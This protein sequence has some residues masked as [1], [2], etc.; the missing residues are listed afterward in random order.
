M[1]LISR[2]SL[3]LF[4]F[5]SFA[6]AELPPL[7]PREVLFGNPERVQP[8]I[9]PDGKRL[10]W[11]APDKNNVLQVWM[12]TVGGS[13]DKVM[14]ADKKRGIRQY[15]WAPSSRMLLYLQDADGDENFHVYGVDIA[16]GAVRDYTP[17]QGV[18]AGVLDVS[19][20]KPDTLLATVNLRDKKAFD[21]YR[22][23]LANGTTA[24]DT[25]NPGDVGNWVADANLAV[26]GA[27]VVTPDGGT[28]L[29][30]R[31]NA[32]APWKTLL[33]A[34]PEENVGIDGFNGDGG[35]IYLE[36]SIGADT[37]R[38]IEKNLKTGAEREIA[39][40]DE[41]DVGGGFVHPVKRSIIAVSFVRGRGEWRVID[42][43]FRDD[44]D[45]LRKLSEGDF[46]VVNSDDAVDNLLV[47]FTQDRGPVKYFA[48][49]RKDKKGTF[50]FTVQPK[51]E[52]LAL[53]EMKPVTIAA[54]D[55]LRLHGYLT[56]PVGVA[57]K[58]LPL[59]LVV[60]GGPWARD[61]WGYNSWVQW[62]ANRGYAVLQ[63]NFRGSTGFGKKFLHAGDRQ[64][65]KT[66]HDD[67]LDGVAWA[68]KEGYADARRVAVFG[69]SYGGYSAL[70]GAAFT[71]DT[72]RCAVDIVGP[73]NLF[74]LL[75]TIPP[76]WATMRALFDTRVGN[77]EDPKDVELLKQ[78]SPLFS[79]D[80]IKIPMLIGQGANDPRVKPAESEQIVAAI[81]KNGG[82]VTYV[83]YSD[84]GHGFQRPENRMDFNARAEEFL[85]AELGG[86]AE[87]LAGE[88]VAG[89]T[90]QVKVVGKK[91]AA[92][93]KR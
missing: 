3:L 64:W 83:L 63:I 75:K 19:P 13:D 10:A 8:K 76:Y 88:R 42:P 5:G 60:H 24:L 28:E 29:R 65:G 52:G 25:Q 77:P 7:I 90:A 89:S 92:G 34:G 69:G 27:E 23:D 31:A 68:V 41:V 50:L 40:D 85:A 48:W 6:R 1:R 67:L 71:P 14:T 78:A 87:K 55:G 46:A 91:S 33:K 45:G 51:L 9:S 73:S 47:A 35:G 32:K 61:L 82:R 93:S 59:V 30:V 66:M 79:A 2:V 43:A 49:N 21:V 38:L 54:R 44:F 58:G 70:A 37:A 12:K 84:E 53:A 62:L 80:K 17:W 36:T 22:I 56:L 72:F 11:L 74:T 16:S 20:R 57:P 4:A 39:R 26:R 81:E 86:R 18:R 15:L